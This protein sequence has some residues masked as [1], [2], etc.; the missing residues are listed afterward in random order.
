MPTHFVPAIPR[1]YARGA[2]IVAVFAAC[3]APAAVRAQHLHGL[4][5]VATLSGASQVPAND[6]PGFAAARVKV[7]YIF[8]TMRVEVDFQGLSGPA[9]AAHIHGLT[10]L[11][12]Q[13]AAEPATALPSLPEFPS[14]QA[15]GAYD[16]TLQVAFAA[17]YNPDFIAAH[18]NTVATAANALF[19]GMSAGRTYISLETEAFPEGEIRG[20]LLP[21]PPADFDFDGEVNAPD[22]AI[23]QR[24]FN[25]DHGGDAT[26]D[27]FTLGDDFLA[28][29][30]QL[31]QAASLPG[32]AQTVGSAVPE[33]PAGAI[34]TAGP[35]GMLA[36]AAPRRRRMK[37]SR[38]YARNWLHGRADSGMMA[39]VE[40][41]QFGNRVDRLC[42]T[43][44]VAAV[45][46]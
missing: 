6:S 35:V 43:T 16:Q 2:A 41:Q 38:A 25:F 45:R 12:G 42:V 11:V 29:Q 22:L 3:A 21:V 15:E 30:R 33:P 7:D 28:W 44:C 46:A 8:F 32:G 17:A 37:I 5:F 20:F 18:G 34:A 10:A 13:G 9:T 36:L 24:D 4:A 23:W 19:S 31:G 40:S 1:Q 27:G 14:G 26:G 39:A